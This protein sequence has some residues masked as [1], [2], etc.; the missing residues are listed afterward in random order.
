MFDGC[1]RGGGA[2]AGRATVP[3]PASRRPRGPTQELRTCAVRSPP[4][5]VPASSSPPRRRSHCPPARPPP[6]GP[7]HATAAAGS[8]GRAR[9]AATGDGSRPRLRSRPGRAPAERRPDRGRRHRPQDRLSRSQARRTM[10]RTSSRPAGGRAFRRYAVAVTALGAGAL[11]AAA[12]GAPPLPTGD[13]RWWLFAALI[14]GGELA[15]IDV[16]RRDGLD[17]VALSTA[18]GFAALLLF[19][20]LPALVAYAAASVLADATA[21]LAPLKVLFNA[22]QY[23]LS[24]AAAPPCSPRSAPP[25]RRVGDVLPA[26]AAAAVTFLLANHVLAGIAAALLAGEPLGRYLLTDLRFQT[27]TSGFVL[28]LAPVVVAC[29]EA[30]MALVP[31][32]G[33]P[34]LALHVGARQAARD[35]HRALARRAHRA[36]PTASSCASGSIARLDDARARERRRHADDRRPRRLQGRQRHARP[37]LRRPPPQ[38]VAAG[39]AACWR[40]STCSPASAATSSPCCSATARTAP[41][42]SRSPAP[43]SRRSSRSSRSTTSRSTSAR[44]WAW[45]ASPSTAPARTSSCAAPTWRSTAPRRPS[46]PSRSTP[47]PRTTTRSTA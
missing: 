32:C 3:S 30:S 24:L 25:R 47:R 35:A 21:R 40:R 43:W 15:P 27:L 5:S 2:D 13:W 33:L 37:R 18:F 38:Q 36:R 23:A 8:P 22:A 7:T 42:A 41:T 20:P 31:L 19:G 1:P 10:T 16:P 28:G 45:R 14:L 6:P 11:A 9:S 29:A 46:V 44:A 34:V 12:H 4:S 26:I 39:C 17:R